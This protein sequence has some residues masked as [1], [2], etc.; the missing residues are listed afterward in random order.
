MSRRT[1]LLFALA[2]AAGLLGYGLTRL[3]LRPPAFAVDSTE[4]QLDWLAREFS[5]NAGARAEV[6]RL[7]S[8]YEPVCENHCAAI[9]RAQASLKTALAAGDASA[10]AAAEAQLARLKQLCA[11]ST[12]AHL[13]AVAAQMPPAQAARFLN[14]MQPRV[15]HAA[16]RTGAPTLAPASAP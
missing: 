12:Q 15:A 16:E 14:L 11:E 10:R 9:A 5:L 3:A 13:R 8:A 2:V 6:A 1:L 7:Q 4:A